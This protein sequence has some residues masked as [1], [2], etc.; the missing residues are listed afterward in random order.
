MLFIAPLLYG[1]FYTFAGYGVY[2]LFDLEPQIIVVK[3]VEE[4]KTV[5][6]NI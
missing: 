2:K 1:M 4:V 3:K 6:K 5:E